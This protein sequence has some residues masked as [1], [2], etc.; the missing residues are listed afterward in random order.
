M[1]NWRSSVFLNSVCDLWHNDYV[2]LNE[3]SVEPQDPVNEALSRKLVIN[4][5]GSQIELKRV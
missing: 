1:S 2:L 5:S 3:H 4:A